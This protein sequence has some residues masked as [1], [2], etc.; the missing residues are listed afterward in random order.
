MTHANLDIVCGF[1][2]AMQGR[3]LP[4]PVA[5]A[6]RRCLVDWFAVSLAALA[7]PAPSIVRERML[8]WRSAGRALSLYGDRL[9]AGPAA[10]I[11]GTACHSLDYDDVHLG[12]A[13]HV[14]APTLAAALAVGAERGCTG[15]QM[16][17]ALAAGFEVGCAMGAEGIGVALADHGWHP[18]GVLGHFSATVAVAVLL[19]LTQDETAHALGLAATQTAGLQASGGSA[20]K[21]FHV[22]K[23]AMN[24]IMAADLAAGGLEAELKLLDD[25]KSGLLGCLFQQPT[26]APFATLGET[27]QI[28]RNSF[29]PYA[30]CQL[31]HAAFEAGRTLAPDAHPGEVRAIRAFVNPLAPKVASRLRPATPMEG[32]FSIPYCVALG[33]KGYTAAPADFTHERMED[34]ALLDLSDVVEVVPDERIE[35]WSA[36][37]ELHYRDGRVRDARTEAA[38]GSHDRPLGWTEIEAKFLAAVT[39]VL[40]HDAPALLRALRAFDAEGGGAEVEAIIERNRET[41]QALGSRAAKPPVHIHA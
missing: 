37:V 19:G 30:A 15:A 20:A 40:G 23:A 29:K 28:E 21:P 6:A 8:R 13:C 26:L 25:P 36:R 35:R 38:L 24:G 7:D 10:L 22:G 5:D 16:L 1:V 18:T 39:P 14:S 32:K 11:N 27:W 33:L 9:A 17:A 12:T 4:A 31:T 3:T 41:L 2:R 34:T